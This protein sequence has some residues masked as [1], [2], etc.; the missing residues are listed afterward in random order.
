VPWYPPRVT[1]PPN[2]LNVPQLF[3]KFL[4]NPLLTIPESVYHEPLVVSRGPPAIVWVTD[5][6]LIRIVLVD[7]CNDFPQD[8]LLRRVL[9]GL[10]GNSILT[11]E[12]LDWRWQQA[13]DSGAALSTC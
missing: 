10:F 12:G 5:P 11:S 6:A 3:I 9:G 8:P 2:P 4:R 1:P 13:P 7:R